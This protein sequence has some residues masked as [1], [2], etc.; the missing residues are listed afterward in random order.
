VLLEKKEKLANTGVGK[1]CDSMGELARIPQ[2]QIFRV[3]KE[4]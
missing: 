1:Q 3:K 4:V 2:D